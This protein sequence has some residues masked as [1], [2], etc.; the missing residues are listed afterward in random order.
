MRHIHID[1][2]GDETMTISI[3]PEGDEV[4]TFIIT[5]SFETMMSMFM[6]DRATEAGSLLTDN[7]IVV[8]ND[9]EDVGETGD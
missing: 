7:V 5:A 1:D 8:P 3:C 6:N 9:V 2:N 4:L